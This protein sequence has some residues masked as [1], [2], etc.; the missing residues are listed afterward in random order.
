M[1]MIDFPLFSEIPRHTWNRSIFLAGSGRWKQDLAASL[2]SLREN[3]YIVL[4]NSEAVPQAENSPLEKLEWYD[5]FIRQAR[6]VAFWF[7]T[8]SDR[9][10]WFNLGTSLE[11]SKLSMQRVT[12]GISPDFTEDEKLRL[13]MEQVRFAQPQPKFYDG[14]SDFSLALCRQ[15]SRSS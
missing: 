13:S 11:R 5:Y 8:K 12:V 4:I 10:L 1:Q 7:D 2:A 3:S 14:F 15:L 6:Y 9:Q